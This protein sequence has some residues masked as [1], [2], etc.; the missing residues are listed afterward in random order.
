MTKY[1]YSSITEARFPQFK[2]FVE[3]E[4]LPLTD[5]L[6]SLD[7]ND[8]RN[9][10]RYSPNLD[11]LI[12]RI[13]I[14]NER[15]GFSLD[16]QDLVD[17]F[18]KKQIE[19]YDARKLNVVYEKDLKTIELQKT[20]WLI[21]DMLPKKAIG[22][23]VGK[24]GSYKT[25]TALNMMYSCSNGLPVFNRFITQK[26]KVFILDEENGLT[27][28][29]ER[30]DLIKNGLN[31]IN[32]SD[33]AFLSFSGA[34]FEIK[35]FIENFEVFINE[36]KPGV[37]VIDSF[38]RVF[39]SDENDAGAVSKIFT[40]IL[41][42]LS[43]KYNVSWLILHH[44]RKGISGR[45]PS[46]ELDEVRGS[47]DI[48][49]YTDVVLYLHRNKGSSDSIILKQLKCRH[50]KELDPKIIQ[51][52]WTTDSLKMECVGD[53]EEQL[54]ADQICANSI[55]KILAENQKISFKASEIKGFLGDSYS[56]PTINRALRLLKDSG[57]LISRKRGYYEVSAKVNLKDYTNEDTYNEK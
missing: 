15:F 47:S 3:Y 56:I 5:R 16:P 1:N 35:E 50:K 52:T 39:R 46:D 29:K 10:I 53:A 34:T 43:E 13:F 11:V 23:L 9:Q 19:D 41:R 21:E 8:V 42:P 6:S 37:I 27:I 33:I 14:M 48:V 51:M 18:D 31:I 40:S 44:L 22:F 55:I 20:E 2:S 45:N 49:N 4:I 7:R 36:Y 38:R 25:Y 26:C 17:A 28:I 30:S 54:L 57:K 12:D 24:R 32:D